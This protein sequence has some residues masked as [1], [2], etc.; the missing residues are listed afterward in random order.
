MRHRAARRATK[1]AA[2]LC[3][4]LVVTAP[5]LA[6]ARDGENERWIGTW[7]ASPQ[8]PE[9]PLVAPT[10]AQFD[11][12]TIRQ[13]VHTTLGG[14]RVRIRLSNEYGAT[15]LRVGAVT[16]ARHAKGHA[17]V[18]GS[19]RA[20]TFAGRASFTI[21][22]GAPALSDAIA[23]DVPAGGDLVVSLFVPT[24]TP[25]STFHSLGVA[26]TYVSPPGDYSHAA[27]MPVASTT[28]SWFFLS[29]INVEGSQKNAAIITFG[30]SITDGYASTPDANRRWPDVLAQRL[31]ADRRTAHLAVL[32]HGISGNRTLFDLIGPNAQARLDRDVLNAPGAKFVIFLEGIN[33]IG[34]PGAFDRANQAVSA[35]DVIAGH[36]Q[37]I[38]RAHERGLKIFGATLTP[39][40]GTSFSGYFTPEGEAKRQAVNQ[41][42]RNSH[43]FDAVIDFD[44]AVRD[45]AHPSRIL[46][47]YDSGDH[48]HPNDVGYEAMGK[49]ID[50]GLFRDGH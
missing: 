11:N 26:T 22:A 19:E 6:P 45:P 18:A 34:F 32:N 35:E 37:I 49:F 21:P 24:P 40:E 47:A 17:I 23:F 41:W 3:V 5:S 27:D 36:Q 10:P 42:I 20:L 33:N 46:P 44:L 29:G 2:W 48:L 1:I 9:P 39:F 28:Q 30:D 38:A 13:I 25:A 16:L 14:K 31:R 15:A 43:A 50:T 12:Q 4:A 8:A 7:A